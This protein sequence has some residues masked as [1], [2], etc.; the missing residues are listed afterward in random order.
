MKINIFI[1]GAYVEKFQNKLLIL[2]LTL[3]TPLNV[4]IVLMLKRTPNVPEQILLIERGHTKRCNTA[5][6]PQ[7]RN[8]RC[9]ESP[10]FELRQQSENAFLPYLVS[11]LFLPFCLF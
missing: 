6:M 9:T 7:D 1:H 5:V 11:D 8:F 3:R 4:L 2:N 10:L